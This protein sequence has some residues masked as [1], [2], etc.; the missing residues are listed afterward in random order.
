MILIKKHIFF[1]RFEKMTYLS[2]NIKK[3]RNFG[4]ETL[5][6]EFWQKRDAAMKRFMAAK[7]RKKARVDEITQSLREDFKEQMGT[8]PKYVNVW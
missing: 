1:G 6:K 2:T 7:E 4:M 5:D 8:Y 3:E